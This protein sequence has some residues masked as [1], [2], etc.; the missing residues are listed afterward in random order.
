MDV[1][2][3]WVRY[4]GNWYSAV[5]DGVGGHTSQHCASQ[6]STSPAAHDYDLSIVLIS[7]FTN[8]L[9][10]CSSAQWWLVVDLHEIRSANK[11][12]LFYFHF[13][14]WSFW[15]RSEVRRVRCMTQPGLC[16]VLERAGRVARVAFFY[17]ITEAVVVCQWSPCLPWPIRLRLTQPHLGSSSSV[18]TG[19]T[20]VCSEL[21]PGLS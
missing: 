11:R 17:T 9:S 16:L 1:L 20:W 3:L 10:G 4:Y 8:L 15:I 12:K 2:T 18:W 5:V 6:Q 19:L 21:G 13:I 7:D 14:E